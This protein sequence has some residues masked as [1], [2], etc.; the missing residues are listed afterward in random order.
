LFISYG[1]SFGRELWETPVGK[2]VEGMDNVRNFYAG[3][4]DMPPWGQGPLQGNIYAEGAAYMEE[5]FPKTDRFLECKVERE[6][7][8]QTGRN[9]IHDLSLQHN[10][11]NAQG[12]SRRSHKQHEQQQ[13]H[14]R[15]GEQHVTGERQH[16]Q[17]V[18]LNTSPNEEVVTKLS[19]E[20]LS[21]CLVLFVGLFA[22]RLRFFARFK[23]QRYSGNKTFCISGISSEQRTKC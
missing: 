8:A 23:H 4:G 17:S 18:L 2:V 11:R 13:H 1:G 6:T 16:Q 12:G 15:E 22:L 14:L 21:S 3:Y 9:Q 20:L 10:I 5:N 7:G 19:W